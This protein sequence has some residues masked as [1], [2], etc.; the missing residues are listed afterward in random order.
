LFQALNDELLQ[1]QK[2]FLNSTRIHVTSNRL[3]KTHFT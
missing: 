3:S 2:K 1:L